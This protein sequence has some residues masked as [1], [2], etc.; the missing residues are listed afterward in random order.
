LH[1]R[2]YCIGRFVVAVALEIR[3][4]ILPPEVQEG[5]VA[6]AVAPAHLKNVLAV[7]VDLAA[8]VA[9]L[10]QIVPLFMVVPAVLAEAAVLLMLKQQVIILAAPEVMVG[11]GVLVA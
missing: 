1:H 11:V 7:V 8:V 5:L 2:I 10:I 3:R 9:V 6:V 4:L